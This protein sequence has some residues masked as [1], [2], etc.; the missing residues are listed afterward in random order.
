MK[1][2]KVTDENGEDTAASRDIMRESLRTSARGRITH[3]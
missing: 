1:E 2:L 3:G